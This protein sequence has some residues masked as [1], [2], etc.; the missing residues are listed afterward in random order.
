M[1]TYLAMK[2]LLKTNDKFMD[3]RKKMAKGLINNSYMNEKV[4]GSP[5]NVRKR[6]LSH[7]LETTPTHATEYNEKKGFA[8]QNIKTKNTSAVG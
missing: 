5:E 1:N 2:Y 8:Q 4:C 3:F 6:Q 7:I